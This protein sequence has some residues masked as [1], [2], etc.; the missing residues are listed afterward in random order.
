MQAIEIVVYVFIAIIAAGLI[1]GALQV[2]DWGGLYRNYNKAVTKEQDDMFKVD[3]KGLAD[4][5]YKRWEECRFGLDDTDFALYVLDNATI[6][7]QWLI[8]E[9]KR[10]DH[11]DAFDCYNKTN[12]LS[13]NPSKTPQIINIRCFNKSLIVG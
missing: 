10:T 6:D 5:I 13:V 7:R 4:E 9:F 8:T 2:V 11:C 12:R 3:S 1:V